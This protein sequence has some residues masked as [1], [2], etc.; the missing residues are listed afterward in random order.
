MSSEANEAALGALRFWAVT[1]SGAAGAATVP[2]AVRETVRR[3]AWL[4][5]GQSGD[6]WPA[7]TVTQPLQSIFNCI[8]V[9]G[10]SP[11]RTYIKRAALALDERVLF[12]TTDEQ[13]DPAATDALCAALRQADQQ[14]ASLPIEVRIEA[15]LYAL[16]R[17]AWCLPSPLDGVSLYDMA[18]T[19]AAVA[20]ALAAH[21]GDLFLVGGDISGVQDFIYTVT[22][23]GAT[24]QL[25]G[26]SF[27]L[28]LLT[29]ACAH[30]LLQSAGM[31]LT[32]L[33]Y[34][35]GGR[36]YLVMPGNYAHK[37]RDARR[38]IGER[39]L[40]GHGGALYL[41]LGGV[42]VDPENYGE[43]DWTEL[44]RAIDEAKRRRF[45]DLSP[46][47]LSELFKPQQPEPPTDDA[48]ET[49]P[50]DMM[51]Q[52]LKELGGRLARVTIL[53]I[54]PRAPSGSP[55]R[56]EARWH[57]VLRS[58]GLHVQ[59]LDDIR[60]YRPDLNQRRRLL[61]LEDSNDVQMLNHM[62]GP[63]DIVGTRYTVAVAQ[64]ATGKDVDEYHSLERTSADE[65]ILNQS[66]V[67][68]FNL[69]AS[70]SV[71]VKRLGV[72]RM[73]VDDLG[74]LFGKGLQRPKGIAALTSTAALSAA[75]SRYFEGWVGELCR[76]ENHDG[77]PGGVYAVYSGG[78]DLF[79]V[80]SWHRMPHLAR[81]IR[82]D[83]ARYV[84]GRALTDKE[85]PP[86]TLSGGITLHGDHYPLYQAA[87]D[88]AEALDAAKRHTRANGRE[89]D[90]ITFLGRT[91]GWED[92]KEVVDEC[93]TLRN[94]IKDKKVSRSLLMV[95]QSLDERYQQGLK[96]R[97]RDG[98]AQF[99]YG[100]WVWQGAYQL[101]RA[102]ERESEEVRRSIEQLRDRIVGN[103]GVRTR[104]IARA[105]MAAR[106]AQ[107][108]VRERNTIKEER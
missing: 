42:C 74:Q 72:I 27:Y 41:A 101:T 35:G 8:R 14:S 61:L 104:Y 108:L 73:D 99:D 88:A 56:H 47:R 59:P 94:L 1:A 13:T 67:K 107:L 10:A 75:M 89:K 85:H 51:G 23:D 6:G 60:D 16:Q 20:A 11:P 98:M 55:H 81:C 96:R 25:R 69:L 63:Q 46:E 28:Q 64:L 52:S 19:H 2:D 103:E 62:L 90:A 65:Q 76:R 92:F 58:L 36:F 91:F 82:D 26:R 106:W 3:A 83:F 45:A 57:D 30:Y 93:V 95:I 78:D 4:A 49:E 24:K 53:S 86:I 40:D 9:A 54:E 68:P 50:S 15:L 33:L 105:G 29:E 34:A 87:D 79:L 100:P 70:Q 7:L 80:G 44:S 97:N 39:L 32:N 12:P 18:R 38:D 17:H 71:G 43:Q 31:P 77:E 5:C 102:A 84:L 66:D 21:D 48:I 22:A 37:L